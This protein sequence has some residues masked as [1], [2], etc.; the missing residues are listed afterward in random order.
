MAVAVAEAVHLVLDRRAIARPPPLD[1][2]GEQGRAVEAG[3][4]DVMTF[5]SLVRVIAQ[6]SCGCGA[7]LV[8][9]RHRPGVRDR[10]A[11]APVRAQSIVRPSSRGGVPVLSRPSASP[12]SRTCAASGAGRLLAEP[13]AAPPLL[14]A[15]HARAEEGAGGDD[16][17]ARTRSP[18]VGQFDARD[19]AAAR[20][21][22]AIA[23]PSISSTPALGD[24]G[25][26]P[27]ADKAC[28]RPGRAGRAPRCPCCG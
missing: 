26:R 12:S 4:N 10:S 18:T 24:Q 17:R 16:H 8:E 21:A 3:A 22:S 7:G 27:R 23:S 25:R 14:A 2:P 9:R 28:G 20:S 13:A 6:A 11:A 19:R 1:R 15:E 5:A